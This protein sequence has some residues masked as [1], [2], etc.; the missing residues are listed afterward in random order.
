[1]DQSTLLEVMAG[2]VVVSAIALLLQVGMLFGML[3]AIL[4][5]RERVL[6]LLPK[7]EGLVDA[8]RVA[9]DE[10]RAGIA[11]VRE[12][13]NE[14]L[15]LTHKQLHQVEGVLS[16]ATE[17]TRKQLDHI[18]VVIEDALER[19][20]ETVALVHKG[21]LKPVRGITG[22]VAALRTVIQVLMRGDRRSPD[23]A[24]VDE[25]MFI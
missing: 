4:T 3:R 7:V 24:T 22:V 2:A 8:S 10:S 18:E 13:T 9:V 1:M 19:V 21:I 12:K 17:R 11:E 14:I 15:D 25:E 23:R 6:H 5:V 20:E 16:D